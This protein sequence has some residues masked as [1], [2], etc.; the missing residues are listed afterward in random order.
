MSGWKLGGKTLA[1]TFFELICLDRLNRAGR[2]FDRW[3]TVGLVPLD[4]E[5]FSG[6]PGCGLLFI[7]V[8]VALA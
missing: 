4:F 7:A 5:G 3:T 8:G 1:V 2:L 6:T